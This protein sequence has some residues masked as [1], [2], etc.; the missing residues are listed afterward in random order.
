MRRIIILATYG[1]CL[2]IGF[3]L[4]VALLPPEPGVISPNPAMTGRILPASAWPSV[5]LPPLYISAPTSDGTSDR[6]SPQ[7]KG[8]R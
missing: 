6:L 7:R 3:T 1:F 4:G 8:P 2:T 5:T